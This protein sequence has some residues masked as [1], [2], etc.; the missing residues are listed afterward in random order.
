MKS[1]L[2]LIAGP[3]AGVECRRG[4]GR[5]WPYALRTLVGVVTGLTLA[6]VL[7]LASTFV[8]VAP[9]WIEP[10]ILNT[11]SIVAGMLL[12]GALLLS[13]AMLAG[14][15][16]GEKDQGT[17]GMLLITSVSPREIVTA[18]L[19]ARVALVIMLLAAGLP[20]L[21][22]LAALAGI[23]LVSGALLLALPAAV[24]WGGGGLALA[25]SVLMRRAREAL[26]LVFMID[27]V[28]LMAPLLGLL[29]I[30]TAVH[31]WLWA[32]NPFASLNGLIE[33]GEWRT[34]SASI[35]MWT[36]LGLAGLATAGW[37]LWPAYHRLERQREVSGAGRG[38]RVP[39]LVDHPMLWKER[40]I[41]RPQTFG[42]VGRGLIHL[43]VLATLVGSVALAAMVAFAR[44]TGDTVMADSG[45][46]LL[47]VL[48]VTPA[49]LLAWIVQWTIGFR[50]A[51]SV[52]SE[53]QRATW[54][55]LLVSPLTGREIIWAKLAGTFVALRWPLTAIFVSWL[56]ALAAG[57][58]PPGD[59]LSQVAYC[60]LI[61]LLMAACGLRVSLTSATTTRAMTV[62]LGLWLAA[63]IAVPI[64]AAML[65]GFAF[66]LLLAAWA[67]AG[68]LGWVDSNRF[69]LFGG[70][71]NMLPGWV[72]GAIWTI[73]NL[74]LYAALGFSVA[75]RTALGFDFL[76]G[77]KPRALP[78]PIAVAAGWGLTSGR[79]PGP[80][81][82]VPVTAVVL[83]SASEPAPRPQ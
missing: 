22:A 33:G 82:T 5:W 40:Y 48:V 62:T 2:E 75:T 66:Y 58:M 72:L 47:G 63:R 7:L 25:T 53:R 46:W 60:L 51:V 81:A 39:P 61:G 41:E 37:R 24:A 64:V 73:T 76:A 26:L 67:V 19:L 59:W 21:A 31:P 10:V 57:V 28:L 70:G 3:L 80:D 23:N 42:R 32:L 68:L 38:W 78:P 45:E 13:P 14:A 55:A 71:S 1:T 27:A 35:G 77:R 65:L 6:G 50:A 20:V 12:V 69:L 17:L 36:F 16:A 29:P 79:A 54:D 30:P 74:A 15:L 18:R 34:T 8:N 44:W 52:A 4:V 9:A 83:G 43:L 49:P 11:L 56:A